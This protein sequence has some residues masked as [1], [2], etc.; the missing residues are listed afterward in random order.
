[1][2]VLYGR[3]GA[4]VATHDD[5]QGIRPAVYGADVVALPWPKPLDAEGSPPKPK[6]IGP[7][8]PADQSDTR[9]Y[10]MPIYAALDLAA[11]ARFLRWIKQTSG[12]LVA[13]S[14]VPTDSETRGILTA[15]YVRARED[16]SYVIS[17]WQVGNVRT[18]L[19]AAQI[20][21]LSLAVEAHVQACFTAQ[22]T[23]LDAIAAGTIT[24]LE[25]LYAAPEWPH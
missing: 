20:I 3:A 8:P 6:R 9:P 14:P 12:V 15:G 2:Q 11:A 1:M 18:S 24:T 23:V 16:A 19:T 13:G 22:A 21:A 25:Q 7:A 5:D 4:I 17:N 10:A